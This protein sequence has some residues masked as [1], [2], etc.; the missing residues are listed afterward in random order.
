[1]RR[2]KMDV[3]RHS[4]QLPSSIFFRPPAISIPFSRFG[5]SETLK[6]MISVPTAGGFFS[7]PILCTC[8]FARHLN[9][10]FLDGNDY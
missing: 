5:N 7:I 4:L 2:I 1:M 8:D 3:S 9:V 10:T 6:L